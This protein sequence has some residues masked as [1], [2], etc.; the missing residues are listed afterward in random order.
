MGSKEGV[1]GSRPRAEFSARWMHGNSSRSPLPDRYPLGALRVLFYVQ[2]GGLAS[3]A[4]PKVSVPDMDS[5]VERETVLHG[6]ARS[7]AKS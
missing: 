1:S 3:I 4:D 2:I 7:V 6:V 5:C